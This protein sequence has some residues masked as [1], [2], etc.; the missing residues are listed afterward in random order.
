[1][2]PV[3]VV[4]DAFDECL[5]WR[6]EIVSIVGQLY[7]SGVRVYI[8]TQPHL[9]DHLLVKPLQGAVRQ[10][11][12]ASESDIKDYVEKNLQPGLDKKLKGETIRTVFSGVDGM[13]NLSHPR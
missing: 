7:D 11:I 12:S 9:L 10:E 6:E 13:Y 4:L 2:A 5:K 8:T 1:M 3:F